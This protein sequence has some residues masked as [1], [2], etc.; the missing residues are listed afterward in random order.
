MCYFMNH[1]DIQAWDTV[2][3]TSLGSLFN[4]FLSHHYSLQ[5]GRKTVL[6]EETSPSFINKKIKQPITCKSR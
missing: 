2:S 6:R 3:S 5:E 4:S 1:T